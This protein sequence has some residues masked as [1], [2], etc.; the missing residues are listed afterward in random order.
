[1]DDEEAICLS[2]HHITAQVGRRGYDLMHIV[3]NI[4]RSLWA[5]QAGFLW[6]FGRHGRYTGAEQHL[7]GVA[8]V[9]IKLCIYD[10]ASVDTS[11]Q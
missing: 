2:Q 7:H 10:A 3:F 4:I 8:L 6:I 11:K 5:G 1:M 9:L